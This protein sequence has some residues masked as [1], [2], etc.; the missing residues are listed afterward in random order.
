M[1]IFEFVMVLVSIVI[2]LGISAL[3]TGL[4]ELLQKR[5]LTQAY[6]L[7]L[8]QVLLQ[9]LLFIA[10]WWTA[11]SFNEYDNWNIAVVLLLMTVTTFFFLAGYL[12]FPRSGD[13]EDFEAYYFTQHRRYY[14]LLIAGFA[15]IMLMSTSLLASRWTSQIP[16]LILMILLGVLAISRRQRVHEVLLVSTTALL[17]LGVAL[18]AL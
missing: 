2:G 3:L 6:W 13:F 5:T 12:V 16:N 15:T 1:S 9:M 8:V 18:T 10:L 4:G 11:W 14:G 7:Q 17:F